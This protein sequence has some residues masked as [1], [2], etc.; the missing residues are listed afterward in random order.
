MQA[1]AVQ[2]MG[3]AVLCAMLMTPSVTEAQGS[4]KALKF[5]WLSKSSVAQ[6]QYADAARTR[7]AIRKASGL[8]QNATWVCSP[9]G[10]GQPSRCAK[11]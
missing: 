10:F 3:I 4:K 5:N 11:G 8:N 9:A 2:K 6:Q 7:A 1:K